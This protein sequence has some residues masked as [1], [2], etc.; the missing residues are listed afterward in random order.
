M[1]LGI[2][3]P[4]FFP[5]LGY[6][7]LI[8]CADKMILY[9]RVNYIK[10]GWINRN[11]I[12]ELK[13][14]PI[15]ITVPVK[16]ASSNKRI[17]DIRLDNSSLWAVRLESLI[18]FNYKRASHFEE[19]FFLLS[20]L[21]KKKYEFLSEFNKELILAICA[22]LKIETSFVWDEKSFTE[23]E[24]I[25]CGF[26]LELIEKYSNGISIIDKK[27]F[28]ILEIC[29]MMNADVYLNPSGGT[30][31]YNKGIFKVN[32]IDLYFLNTLQHSYNQ[33]QNEFYPGL[34]IIDVLMHNGVAGT[35]NP[36]QKCELI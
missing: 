16:N 20:T 25:I 35:R 9:D 31:L 27:T 22:L 2:M 28:R 26:N 1:K 14:G 32:N 34:S 33:N 6:F 11:R 4:Y 7:Q 8:N 13:K 23:L 19:I 29:R 3:Q 12:L 30:K 21:I 36:L 5:Y 10:K 17:S 18:Y 24:N 15:Y